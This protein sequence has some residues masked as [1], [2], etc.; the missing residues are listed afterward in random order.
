MG[1]IYRVWDGLLIITDADDPYKPEQLPI[2]TRD[3][4]PPTRVAVER[5]NARVPMKY[6]DPTPLRVV[7]DDIKKAPRVADDPGLQIRVDPNGLAEAEV[8][9]ESTVAIVAEGVPLRTTLRCLLHSLGLDYYIDDGLL[10]ISEDGTIEEMFRTQQPTSPEPSGTAI[11]P[12]GATENRPDSVQAQLARLPIPTVASNTVSF[13][14]QTRITVARPDDFDM[15]GRSY[16]IFAR[17]KTRRGGTIFSKTSE[18]PGLEGGAALSIRT[19]GKPAF[20]VRKIGHAETHRLINDDNWHA[21][22]MTYN[23]DNRKILFF[24]DGKRDQ[25]DTLDPGELLRE[26]VV[27][28]G[29]CPPNFPCPT[30]FDGQISEVRFYQRALNEQQIAAL[31]TK[32]PGG[33]PAVAR[34]RFDR[35]SGTSIRDETGN[36]HEGRLERLPSHTKD[37]LGELAPGFSILACGGG[38]WQVVS[39]HFGRERAIKTSP[40]DRLAPCILRAEVD[41]P[42]GRRTLLVLDVSHHPDGDWE[43]VVRAD[44]RRL[45]DEIIGPMTTENGWKEITVDL[46]EFAGLKVNLELLNQAN[47]WAN[48]YAY[49]GRIAIVPEEPGSGQ[50][51][52]DRAGS[53]RVPVRKGFKVRKGPGNR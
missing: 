23:H 33:D 1:L 34:W 4:S 36:G 21:V 26:S 45:C 24:I 15:T 40:L 47:D 17:V 50:K 42:R 27:R 32:E 16:T 22:A 19:E 46:S 14:G 51:R 37:V 7:L 3:H 30:Y 52:K 2:R 53:E 12:P 38:G 49:W 28:I 39:D 29:Y 25:E 11:S 6:P 9:M 41:V 13:D 48:E 10:V 44:G 8:S 5:L 20:Y 18:G 35:L 31:S 43:L